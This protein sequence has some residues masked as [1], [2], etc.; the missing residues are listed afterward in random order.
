[1]LCRIC[2]NLRK[3]KGKSVAIAPSPIKASWS[4]SAAY[5]TV[6]N[7]R[8]IHRGD[9]RRL[10]YGPGDATVRNIP[11]WRAASGERRYLAG[12]T[13]NETNQTVFFWHCFIFVCYESCTKRQSRYPIPPPRSCCLCLW[14]MFPMLTFIYSCRL[15]PAHSFWKGANAL[16]GG[17]RV[18][19][20]GNG[21][22]RDES[23]RI[24]F[25]YSFVASKDTRLRFV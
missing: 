22:S 4:A 18:L 12:R 20:A 2:E 11:S 1:M 17:R 7:N 13:K 25:L 8:E 23:K 16:S 3:G 21:P 24:L 15:L 10:A 19:R 9:P 6:P 14:K 5:N